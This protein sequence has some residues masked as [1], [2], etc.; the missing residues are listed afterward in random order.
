[1]WVT[2]DD[3]ECYAKCNCLHLVWLV[4]EISCLHRKSKFH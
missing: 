2:L 1:V 3:T 4:F